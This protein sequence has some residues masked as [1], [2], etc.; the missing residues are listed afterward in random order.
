[1]RRLLRIAFDALTVLSFIFALLVAALWVRSYWANESVTYR[2]PRSVVG[3]TSTSI[4]HKVSWSVGTFMCMRQTV[5]RL[6]PAAGGEPERSLPRLGWRY[7]RGRDGMPLAGWIPDYIWTDATGTPTPDT[8]PLGHRVLYIHA[9]YPWAFFG[10]LPACWLFLRVAHRWRRHAGRCPSCG[11]DL[12][13]TPDRCPE[14]GTT[15]TEKGTETLHG[16]RAL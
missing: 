8:N 9:V 12:R 1:M 10:L 2:W 7:E 6:V 15:A 3:N 16:V 4:V 13:A 5:V 14:C 11:Y